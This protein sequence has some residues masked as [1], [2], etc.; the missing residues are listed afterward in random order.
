M[1][2]RR[3]RGTAE[4]GGGINA[5][6]STSALQYKSAEECSKNEEVAAAVV[7][8]P[9]VASEEGEAEVE[10]EVNPALLP[11]PLLVAAKEVV[12]AEVNPSDE[13]IRGGG[14]E[15]I[16]LLARPVVASAAKKTAS[17]STTG[18]VPM[19]DDVLA[20]LPPRSAR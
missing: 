6:T 3:G 4:R 10:V 14:G 15:F 9:E 18:R 11:S 5:S 8:G 12:E 20:A 16:M 13:G 17:G 2:P 19:L 7:S 1:S